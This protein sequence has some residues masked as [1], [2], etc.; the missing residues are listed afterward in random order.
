[1]V[2]RKTLK[3]FLPLCAK[4]AFPLFF[5]ALYVFARHT[6]IRYAFVAG[7]D[8]LLI[9]FVSSLAAK[10]S[11][12][13]SY[14]LSSLLLLV[15][16]L[17]FATLYW[18][19]SFVAQ[20]MIANL[21][22]VG[23][24]SGNFAKYGLTAL[25]V[26]LFSFLPCRFPK[27]GGRR[28]AFSLVLLAVL[29]APIF[30]SR[31]NYKKSFAYALYSLAR[32][33]RNAQK[34]REFIASLSDTDALEK[35]FFRDGVTDR[36]EKPAALPEKPNV[37]LIF[38]EGFS[39][40]VIDDG[41][42][43]TPNVRKFQ[44]SAITFRNY[45]NHTFATFMGLQGQLYSG[46]Q[47]NNY[48]ENALISLQQI[49]KDNG[50]RTA[51]ILTE[52]KSPEMVGY[53]DAMRF[54]E[55]VTES[56]TGKLRGVSQSI[57]DRDA[58]ELLFDTALARREGGSPF[59]I[60]MY[61][62]GTHCSIDSIDEKFGDGSNPVLNRFFDMDTQFGKFFGRFSESPLASDT[63]LVFTT[64]H[65]SYQ[66]NDF[67]R[68][69]PEHKRPF[70]WIDRVPLSIFYRGIPPRTVDAQGRNSIDLAP[71][72]LDLLD[73]S[74]RNY[75][76]G[77]SLFGKRESPF[78]TSFNSLGAYVTTEDGEPKVLPDENTGGGIKQD[79]QRYFALKKIP[80]ESR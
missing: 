57:S 21:D 59:F 34:E 3:D 33:F 15:M 56:E 18:G 61:T 4:F 39:Q 71:T 65:A 7:A 62:L 12:P 80:R 11:W 63:I 24:I 1:M 30:G 17:E 72:I 75:F 67:L 41:R 25:L 36:I 5:P 14:I 51:Y 22:F 46:Y 19:N 69:F 43:I 6:G 54:D 50:Y 73:I 28:A 9:L 10:K 79:I 38:T 49:L 53:I 70:V 26:A 52:P 48:D 40:N 2:N 64:D 68:T 31:K 37:I 16:N 35:R 44:D 77:N 13:L 23:E 60:A 29:Y 45:Y 76:L 66:D 47:Q 55:V 42:N 27:V 32:D 78:E 74:G 20:Y 8:S 58:Y